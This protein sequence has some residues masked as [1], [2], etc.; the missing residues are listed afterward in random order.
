MARDLKIGEYVTH[1]GSRAALDG[2]SYVRCGGSDLEDVFGRPGRVARPN[3]SWRSGRKVEV[4][5]LLRN[6]M[7]GV[8]HLVRGYASPSRLERTTLSEED[9]YRFALLE[10]AS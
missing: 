6:E 4:D 7:S 1:I 2:V 9:A 8:Y 10:L 3:Q 5:W